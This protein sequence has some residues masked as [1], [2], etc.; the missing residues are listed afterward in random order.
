VPSQPTDPIAAL[1]EIRQAAEADVL[2]RISSA[3]YDGWSA[4][5]PDSAGPARIE[6]QPHSLDRFN[7]ATVTWVGGDN[8]TDDPTVVVERR[9]RGAWH[10]YAD[11]SGAIQVVLDSRPALTTTALRRLSGTQEWRWT[12]SMEVFDAFPRADVPG[13]QVPNGRYRFVIQ[14]H[15]HRDGAVH[16]YRLSSN[17]FH[18]SAWRGISVRRLEVN[19]RRAMFTIAPIRYPRMPREHP[20]KLRFY[21][22]DH[23]GTRKPG[24]SI[25]CITCTFRPWA[26]KGHVTS[27]FVQIVKRSHVVRR[28]RAHRLPGTRTWIASV[29]LS[30]GERVVVPA[31]AV[32]DGY[33]ETNA[34]RLVGPQLG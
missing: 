31:G 24:S 22:D 28:I 11:Q 30:H 6:T 19:D 34:H 23:G 12:A 3:Y 7:D 33:G 26:S 9:K 25:V 4:V 16:H 32:R 29:Q 2:G 27:A 14:G 5:I 13:G 15:I 17:A 10:R 8:W 18:V 1:D 20:S 21:R